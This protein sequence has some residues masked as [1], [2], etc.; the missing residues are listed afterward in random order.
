MKFLIFIFNTSEICDDMYMYAVK[1]Y[2]VVS[3]KEVS[4]CCAGC[5]RLLQVDNVVER[6][7]VPGRV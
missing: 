7:V 6:S 3:G 4:C 2:L 5:F 1:K